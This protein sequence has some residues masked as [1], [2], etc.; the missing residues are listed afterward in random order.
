MISH[1]PFFFFNDTATTEI[2]TLSLHD[3][4]PICA[5]PGQLWP[6]ADRPRPGPVLLPAEDGEPPR[7]AALERRLQPGA[8]PPGHP[9]RHHPRDRPHRDLPCGVR[10]GGDPL[11]EIGRASCRERV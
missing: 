5:V 11:R 8:G 1:L 7:G 4:L 3:A 6:E 2:Y 9:A 10:D